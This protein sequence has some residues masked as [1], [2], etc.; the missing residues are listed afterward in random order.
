M[1][2][3]QIFLEDDKI[4]LKSSSQKNKWY[5]INFYWKSLVELREEMIESDLA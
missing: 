3:Q 4:F 5:P 1:N 2:S